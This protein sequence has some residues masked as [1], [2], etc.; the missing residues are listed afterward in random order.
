[1]NSKSVEASGKTLEAAIASGLD[2]LACTKDQVELEIIQE[3]TRGLFGIGSKDFIVRLVRKMSLKDIASDFITGLC[4]KMDVEVSV[5][6]EEDDNQIRLNMS[7]PNMGVLIGHR[8][9]T[10][11]ALQYLTSLVINSKG[12]GKRVLLDTENYRKKREESL[13]RLARKLASKV[14]TSGRPVSL[15]PMTPY[16]RRILHATLQSDPYVTTSSE[17][18]EPNRKVVVSPK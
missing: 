2:S 15:E 8:G 10:L 1:L 6:A 9:E 13:E 3:G 17:G 4:E 5:Q 14:R 16:E 7:G 11:D 12:N 18:A